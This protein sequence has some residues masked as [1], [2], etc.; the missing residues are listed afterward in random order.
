MLI[1]GAALIKKWG[2]GAPHSSFQ[3]CNL[4][5]YAPEKSQNLRHAA[6]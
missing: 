1:V 3:A 5:K 2:A 6:V 4:S